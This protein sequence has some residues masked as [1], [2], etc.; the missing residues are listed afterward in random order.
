[1]Q[2]APEIFLTF[3]PVKGTTVEVKGVTKGTLQ[4]G[5][6]VADAILSTWIGPRPGPGAEFKS[7][8][9]GS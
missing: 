5:K 7:G 8:V 9:L 4:G 1:M 2:M 3:V 6:A